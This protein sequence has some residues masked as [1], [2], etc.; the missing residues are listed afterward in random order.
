MIR[1]I[2]YQA[3]TLLTYFSLFSI[4]FQYR[5][6]NELVISIGFKYI[7]IIFLILLLIIS[8]VCIFKRTKIFFVFLVKNLLISAIITTIFYTNVILIME[9]SLSVYL[10]NQVSDKSK[11]INPQN[12][13]EQ[14]FDSWQNGDFQI[15]K[16]LDEQI[17]IGNIEFA[18]DGRYELTVKGNLINK[19]IQGI[20]TILNLN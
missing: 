12:V 19:I 10:L 9:R 14:I 5:N 7:V 1:S 18:Q 11:N 16:R 4:L 20:K 15:T 13:E 17:A 8:I 6:Q 3:I 2:I